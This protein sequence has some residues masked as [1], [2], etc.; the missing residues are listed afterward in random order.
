MEDFLNIAGLVE[1]SIV[2]GPGVRFVIFVQGC[3]H[4][5]PGCHNPAT[6]DFDKGTQISV[7][8]LYSRIH[9]NPLVR[10]VTFSGGE[11]FCQ[12]APLAKLGNRLREEGY[13]VF[14]Y[15]GYTL[16][17]LLQKAK[18]QP[19]VKALLTAGNYLVDGRFVL[20]ERD[21]SLRFRGSH[22][23]RIYDITCYPNSERIYDAE[24][25]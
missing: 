12:A 16:A 13:S 22:N 4:H 21:L 5:C 20:A 17:E 9:K 6:H 19:E 18:T 15:S 2:D 25:L 14:I 7:D 24:D 1:E 11:P 23:Q 10:G 3:P 8:E